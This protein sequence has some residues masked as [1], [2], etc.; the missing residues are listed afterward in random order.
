MSEPADNSGASTT[1]P[2]VSNPLGLGP[3]VRILKTVIHRPDLDVPRA[4][5]KVDDIA[6]LAVCQPCRFYLFREG[7]HRCMHIDRSCERL[8]LRRRK[9][10]CPINA[11]PPLTAPQS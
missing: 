2:K 7:E 1:P 3:G 11:W 4:V 8:S 9:E 10:T 5:P 6:R